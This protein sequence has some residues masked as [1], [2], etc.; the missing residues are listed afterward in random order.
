M[1]HTRFPPANQFYTIQGKYIVPTIEPFWS[2]HQRE[3]LGA[4]QNEEI[5]VLG[6]TVS[7]SVIVDG[8]I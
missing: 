5:V 4:F 2:Q 1:L 8:L 6:I 3:I 7:D